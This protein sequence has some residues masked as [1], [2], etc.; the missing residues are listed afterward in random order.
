MVKIFGA[1]IGRLKSVIVNTICER[2]DL[3]DKVYYKISCLLRNVNLI[4][5]TKSALK[6]S[7]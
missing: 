2:I 7:F 1:I 4:T 3:E 5:S 6:K